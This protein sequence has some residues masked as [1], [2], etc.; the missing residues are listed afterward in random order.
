LEARGL[1]LQNCIEG[2]CA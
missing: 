2:E 1:R